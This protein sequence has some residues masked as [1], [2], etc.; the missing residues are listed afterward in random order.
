M[1]VTPTEHQLRSWK[2]YGYSNERIADMC[3]TTT[4]AISR[5]LQEIWQ[6]CQQKSLMERPLGDPDEETLRQRCEEIQRGWSDRE[7]ERRFVGRGGR[8]SPVVVPAS[9]RVR[10][11]N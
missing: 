5:R 2:R 10:A 3:G 7:R 11:S 9:V 6:A 4:S 8:W 1:L